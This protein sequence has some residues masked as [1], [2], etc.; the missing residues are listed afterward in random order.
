MEIPNE[1]CIHNIVKHN[2]EK[3]DKSYIKD[4]VIAGC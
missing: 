2:Q 4:D 1:I 3:L